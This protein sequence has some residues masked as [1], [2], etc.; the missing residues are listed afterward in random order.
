MAETRQIAYFM[1]HSLFPNYI[2]SKDR[3]L[4]GTFVRILFSRIA[5]KD[6]FLKFVS[7]FD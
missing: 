2:F 6:V 4:I 7:C 3:K 5:F 1:A